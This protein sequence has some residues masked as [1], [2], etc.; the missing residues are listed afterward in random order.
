MRVA[1]PGCSR[2]TW[3]KRHREGGKKL[4]HSRESCNSVQIR[5]SESR[6]FAPPTIADMRDSAYQQRVRKTTA[7]I[8]Q[9]RG[10]LRNGNLPRIGTRQVAREVVKNRQ[11]MEAKKLG[12]A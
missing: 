5:P 3:K 1:I 10:T 2:T 4:K 9:L 12:T 6:F 11:I 8:L 7:P